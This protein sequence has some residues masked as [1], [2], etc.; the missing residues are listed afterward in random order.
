V[1]LASHAANTTF[2]EPVPDVPFGDSEVG[3]AGPRVKDVDP[4]KVVSEVDAAAPPGRGLLR[5]F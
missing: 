5:M 4:P 3:L 2:A 1:S